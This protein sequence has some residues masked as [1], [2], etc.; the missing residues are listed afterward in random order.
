MSESA[1][2]HRSNEKSCGNLG[3]YFEEKYPLVNC[4]HC[5]HYG[6]EGTCS[7]FGVVDMVTGEFKHNHMAMF[8]REREDLCGSGARHFQDL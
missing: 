5:K 3:K 8:M 4:A 2:Y 1:Y 7:R 6:K